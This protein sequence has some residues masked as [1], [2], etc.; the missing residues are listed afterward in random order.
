MDRSDEEKKPVR[1][2]GV[3]LAWWM[4][5]RVKRCQRI[6]LAACTSHHDMMSFL[7]RQARKYFSEL[8]RKLGFR[9]I[10][11][12]AQRWLILVRVKMILFIT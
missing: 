3:L 5:G 6:G 11:A 12:G 2:T 8:Y 9:L 10:R 7:K 4:L 1:A